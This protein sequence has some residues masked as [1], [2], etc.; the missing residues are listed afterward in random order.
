MIAM[1]PKMRAIVE[2]EIE[3]ADCA[4]IDEGDCKGRLTVQHA[5]GRTIQERWMF[6]YICHEHHQGKRQNKRRDKYLCL[7][8]ATE[9]DFNKYPKHAPQWRQD[10][11]Y[12]ITLYTI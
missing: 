5:Y 2:E 10:K 4:R 8:Q 3:L 6:I 9:K 11:K 12:L 7:M 1:T